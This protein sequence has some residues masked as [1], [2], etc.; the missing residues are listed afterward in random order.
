MERYAVV[1]REGRDRLGEGPVWIAEAGA[2]AW[3][4]IKGQAVRRLE[5]ASGKVETLTL[6]EPVGWVLPRAGHP[7]LIAGLKSG[8]AF[9]DPA[10][11]ALEPL[12]DPEPERP[13]NRLND[14]KVD[15]WG[16]IWAG[17]MD[18]AEQAVSGALYR[19]DPDHRWSRCDEGYRVANGPTFS[20]DGAILYHTDSAARTVYAF[21]LSPVGDLSNKR[22]WL[23]FAEAWGHPDGMTTDAEGCLWIAHWGGG[24]ISRFSPEG[25]LMKSI[26]LPA[27][28]I[29]NCVF[30][31]PDLDR[32]F[33]TSASIGRED[34]PLAGALFEVDPGV[35]GL[36]A[37][38]YAG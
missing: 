22:V 10:T 21:D 23:T 31:G 25:T 33:V 18:D 9:L 28:N 14:A 32:M 6:N 13:G 30:A 8:F 20:L 36:G 38:D 7:G 26:S 24:R 4:D 1:K 12:G 15:R 34:E 2:V 5:L 11:G 29:T 37:T 35:R 16:R 17:S 3:V 19:L 27:S